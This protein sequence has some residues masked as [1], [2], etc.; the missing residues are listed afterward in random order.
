MAARE[1]LG[2]EELSFIFKSLAEK[3]EEG[4]LY[5]KGSKFLSGSL[6]QYLT[7]KLEKTENSIVIKAYGSAAEEL[8]CYE[9][10]D[11]GDVDIMIFP[12]SSKLTIPE[13][14]LEYSLENPLHVRIRG[15]HH[16]A[17][18]PCL[19]KHTEYVAT[20]AVKNFHPAIFGHISPKL[21]NCTARAILA[22]SSLETLSPI[23]T[24]HLK[25]KTTSPALS[26]NLS[27]SLGT[28]S[29][30]RKQWDNHLLISKETQSVP[31]LTDVVKN[32]SK[33]LASLDTRYRRKVELFRNIVQKCRSNDL[34]FLP[35]LLTDLSQ[36]HFSRG[37]E[38]RAGLQDTESRS[39]N[40]SKHSDP[41]SV[42]VKN[43]K[44]D[45]SGSNP[46][47]CFDVTSPSKDGS[48]VTVTTK[49]C[50]AVSRQS[51]TRRNSTEICSPLPEELMSKQVTE[52]EGTEGQSGEKNGGDSSESKCQSKAEQQ[53]KRTQS[54]SKDL[55]SHPDAKREMKKITHEIKTMYNRLVEHLFGAGTQVEETK[56][57]GTEK[58]QLH[59]RVK[60]GM[61]IVPAFRT[62]GWPEVA[63]EWISRD[64]K[65]PSADIVDKVIQEGCHL[66]VKPP[67][68]N[69]NPDCDFRISFSHAEYLLSQEMN[70]IQRECYR[71]LKRYHRAYLSTQPASLV[72]FHL[73]NILL[74]TIE[75]TG[76]ETWTESN[77][78][79]CVMK[80]LGN[81][82]KALTKKDLRH[83][84]VRSYNLFSVDY[85]EDPKIL[86]ILAWKVEQ[87]MSDPVRFSKELIQKQAVTRQI[88]MDDC[89]SEGNVPNEEAALSAK[90]VAGQ[91]DE[92]NKAVPCL[93]NYDNRHKKEMEAQ[94]ALLTEDAKR[95]VRPTESGYRYHGLNEIISEI[96]NKLIDHLF[97][98][99]KQVSEQ[100]SDKLD[101]LKVFISSDE[102]VKNGDDDMTQGKTCE[103]A[104]TLLRRI[105]D[106]SDENPFNLS[107]TS[108]CEAP[109]QVIN[110]SHGMPL[111]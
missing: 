78:A 43:G 96:I 22:L 93:G 35:M 44:D 71:C 111:D 77:R 23:V 82:L 16:S 61:D 70:H 48:S 81:L 3:G 37:E 106:P 90:S 18:Q 87:I 24:A 110:N 55:P 58:T 105:L 108:S 62:R 88:K 5:E 53:Q 11:L 19:V 17:L 92:G 7:S 95:G 100:F 25:N 21:V 69:G 45:E 68:N 104:W 50:G 56:F 63:R 75:E 12:N 6:P 2:R 30:L 101:S 97:Q 59:E 13:E 83:F 39:Q 42:T 57:Q 98:E 67:R 60:F 31:S 36:E 76:V 65:W 46:H 72:T 41:Q 86:E 73:K 74:Q 99:I 47:T 49:T 27:Q 14:R 8:T 29:H 89:V 15:D 54:T 80:L 10:C 32:E 103:E 79:G 9:P 91:R 1:D 94:G 109:S 33:F 84:F 38:I 26:L 20:S 52:Y 85:I 51:T 28:V 4:R 34:E 102:E 40:K 66:V 64:R 107:H